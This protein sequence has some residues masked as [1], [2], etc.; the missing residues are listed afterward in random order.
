MRVASIGMHN[1]EYGTTVP[2]LEILGLLH[3]ERRMDSGILMHLKIINFMVWNGFKKKSYP[4]GTC[5]RYSP[6]GHYK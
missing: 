5:R 6:F 4:I 1:I 2:V 3:V